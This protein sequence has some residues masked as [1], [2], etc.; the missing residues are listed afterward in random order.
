MRYC[1]TD[2]QAAHGDLRRVQQGVRRVQQR[3]HLRLR[4]PQGAHPGQPPPRRTKMCRS[5]NN[6]HLLHLLVPPRPLC[7]TH[8]HS[9]VRSHR[10]PF[11]LLP[12]H[13][14]DGDH[15]PPQQ[16]HRDMIPRYLFQ[17]ELARLR[18]R[19]LRLRRS[20]DP[21]IRPRAGGQTAVS[22]RLLPPHPHQGPHPPSPRRTPLRMRDLCAPHGRLLETSVPSL[23]SCARCSW[24]SLLG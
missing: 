15:R 23:L 14:M 24:E 7:F 13:G 5:A 8:H 10:R 22:Q 12:D 2:T 17:R 6:T 11:L 19:L 18:L 4:Q 1:G 16:L 9:H 21:R 20:A 3:V